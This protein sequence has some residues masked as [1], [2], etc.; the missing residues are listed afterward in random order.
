MKHVPLKIYLSQ[1][2]LLRKPVAIL[3]FLKKIKDN[4]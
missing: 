2:M 1:V 3:G 4:I